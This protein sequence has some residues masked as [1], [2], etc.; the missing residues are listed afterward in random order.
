[1]RPIPTIQVVKFQPPYAA[2]RMP[3]SAPK[4]EDSPELATLK[5]YLRWRVRRWCS[6]TPMGQEPRQQRDFARLSG[7]SP[8]TVSNVING[9]PFSETAVTGI[10]K[11]LKL[12]WEEAF[13]ESRKWRSSG[14]ETGPGA[15]LRQA[16]EQY[17][18]RAGKRVNDKALSMLV[19]TERREGATW[20]VK[21]WSTEIPGIVT[22]AEMFPARVDE[23]IAKG[24]DLA[25]HA[26][27]RATKPRPPRG[28][29]RKAESDK[30][31]S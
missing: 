25:G 8:G 10:L 24:G 22:A 30:R 7:L 17:E 11:V 29:S 12:G 18:E 20:T 23:A 19:L 1:M 5:D 9:G 3:R 21:Q 31:D 14:R 2:E 6:E 16:I 26:L 4:P 28:S 27:S 13:R 15:N